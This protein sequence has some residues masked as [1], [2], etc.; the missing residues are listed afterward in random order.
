LTPTSHIHEV[1]AEKG[2]A[3]GS[4]PRSFWM[5]VAAERGSGSLRRGRVHFGDIEVAK[6]LVHNV[7]ATTSDASRMAWTEAPGRTFGVG[8]RLCPDD[9]AAIRCDLLKE[10]G[11]LCADLGASAQ[12]RMQGDGAIVKASGWRLH[13]LRTKLPLKLNRQGRPSRK[14][15]LSSVGMTRAQASRR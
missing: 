9:W 13:G 8:E 4:Q 3:V 1:C 7:S 14:F 2:V 12:D 10:Q 11:G 15:A 5:P 6:T